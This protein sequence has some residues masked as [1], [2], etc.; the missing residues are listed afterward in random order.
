MLL[1][2]YSQVTDVEHLARELMGQVRTFVDLAQAADGSPDRASHLRTA[3][4]EYLLGRAVEHGC[5]Q[6]RDQLRDA[7]AHDVELNAQ[8]LEVW[9]DKAKK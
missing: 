6:T 9:L 1:T 3:I 8:G 4:G 2:H 5:P 7:L